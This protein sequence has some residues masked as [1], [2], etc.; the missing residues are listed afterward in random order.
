MP[1]KRT[2]GDFSCDRVA[3]SWLLLCEWFQLHS[4]PGGLLLLVSGFA[5]QESNKKR[6]LPEW[7]GLIIRSGSSGLHH[8]IVLPQITQKGGNLP[9]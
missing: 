4:D 7:N 5:L 8:S 1:S 6:K 3:N 2:R 9:G